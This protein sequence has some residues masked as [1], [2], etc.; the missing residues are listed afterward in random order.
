M[1]ELKSSQNQGLDDFCSDNQSAS[2]QL[3]TLQIKCF[4]NTALAAF[5]RGSNA[6]SSPFYLEGELC[7][8]KYCSRERWTVDISGIAI[9]ALVEVLLVCVEDV[10][11]TSVNL[12]AD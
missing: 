11:H 4:L 7:S 1:R 3:N 5:D 2:K 9:R 12:K 8:D 6:M 10:F